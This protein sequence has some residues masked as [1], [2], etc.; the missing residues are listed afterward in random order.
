[1]RPSGCEVSAQCFGGRS[2]KASVPLLY[3]GLAPPPRMRR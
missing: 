2:H 1:L 3:A